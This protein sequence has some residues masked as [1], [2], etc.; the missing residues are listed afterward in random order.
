MRVLNSVLLAASLC[1][2]AGASAVARWNGVQSD[3]YVAEWFHG[4]ENPITGLSCCDESDGH[5]LSERDW[6][7]AAA[8][9]EVKIGKEWVKVPAE[10]VL[11]RVPNPT[12]GAVAFYMPWSTDI[13][14]FVRP[15]EA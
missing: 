13:Y 1:T 12:G 7:V 2:L 10:A 6:R 8:G 14:C 11:S 4:L 5:I 9:Y 15:P 3:P